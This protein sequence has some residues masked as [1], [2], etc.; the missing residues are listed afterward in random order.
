MDRKLWYGKQHL[1]KQV[2]MEGHYYSKGC[3]VVN[4]MGLVHDHV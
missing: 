3:C 2:E 4:W 1:E